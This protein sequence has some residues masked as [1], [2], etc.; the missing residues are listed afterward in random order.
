MCLQVIKRDSHQK[1]RKSTIKIDI[2]LVYPRKIAD[3]CH[4]GMAHHPIIKN[5]IHGTEL[6]LLYMY[7]QIPVPWHVFPTSA[8]PQKNSHSSCQ[9]ALHLCRC[10]A[11]TYILLSKTRKTR[12]EVKRITTKRQKVLIDSRSASTVSP[13]NHAKQNFDV[14][15]SSIP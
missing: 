15:R 12:T 2:R 14:A 4:P 3:S 8:L 6:A 1:N 9:H 10:F 13:W 7:L 11:L 5:Y